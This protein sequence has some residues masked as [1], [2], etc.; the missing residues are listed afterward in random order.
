LVQGEDSQFA[1]LTDIEGLEDAL[2]DM[3]FKVAGTAD[4]ITAIQMDIKVPGIPV[5]VMRQALEQARQARLFIIDRMLDAISRSRP[6]L[7]PYAPRLLKIHVDPDKIRFIIGPGGKTIRSITD[8]CKVTID[9]EDDGSVI[10]GSP[11]EEA[12]QKAIEMIME[13]TRD[14][15]VGGIYR[16]KVTRLMDFGAFVQL[17]EGVEGLI[18][19]SEMTYERRISHPRELLSEGE[20]VKV[21]VLQVDV[22]ARRIGLSIKQVGDDPWMGASVRWP[23]DSVAEGTVKRTTEF[24]AFVELTP[25]VESLIH[26]SELSDGRVRAVTDVVREGETVQAKVLSVDEDQRRIALSVKQLAAMPGYTGSGSAED[27]PARPKKKRKK[28]LKGGLDW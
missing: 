5:E 10:I 11:D 3:D 15:E 1:I 13:L 25:G 28:P 21:R 16:G 6:D 24:G 20:M 12:A 9:V 4:G 7:S 27:Q 26:I 19:I 17:E 22:E 8:E 18:P 23:I 14:V 2:G